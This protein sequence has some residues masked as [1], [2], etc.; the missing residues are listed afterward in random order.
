MKTILVWFRNDL[1]IRDNKTLSA[2]IAMADNI[3]PVYCF[4][5]RHFEKTNHYGLPKT[6]SFRANFTLESVKDLRFA[7]QDLGGDLIIR[8]G[9]PEAIVYSLAKYHEVDAVYVQEEVCREEIEVEEQLRRNLNTIEVPLEYF[10]GSTLYHFDD[11]PMEIDLL[12]DIF[13]EFRKAVEKKAN[14]RPT[15]DAPTAITIPENIEKGDLPTLTQLGLTEP[16][17]DRR[18]VLP[19]KGGE[20]E[21]LMRLK[22]YFWESDQ[23]KVYKE[24][25]NGLLGADYSSKFSPWLALGCISPRTIAKEIA[26]YE[27]ERTK[28]SS[29]YWLIFELIWRDY[30]RFVC[31]KYGD[32]VFK[33]G[34]IKKDIRYAT[35]NEVLFQKWADGET[36]VPFIDANMREL[37]ST[38]FMSNR[39]RQNVASF[40]VKDLGLHWRM[41]AEYFESFLLDY[42]PCSNYGNWNYVAGIGNDPREDRYFNVLSQAKRYDPNGDY[43]KHWLPELKALPTTRIHEPYLLNETEQTYLKVHL[44][45]QYPKPCFDIHKWQARKKKKH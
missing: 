18:G 29:T 42:D 3:I 30:F 20:T 43:V 8:T 10:W 14:I 38:G 33:A 4:D 32:D 12:P 35:E 17:T 21:A 40:L 36:G 24:T 27:E 28:N 9:K 37:N 26:K 23:L 2:A 5:P 7:L 25:R 22:H 6:N 39:G 15:I 31:A 11:L 44:G 1:R 19:F 16:P 34:G 41:G 45:K 13:T